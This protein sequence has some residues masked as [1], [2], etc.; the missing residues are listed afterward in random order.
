MS[1]SNIS[2]KESTNVEVKSENESG[3]KDESQKCENFIETLFSM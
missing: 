1:M 2:A 3:I